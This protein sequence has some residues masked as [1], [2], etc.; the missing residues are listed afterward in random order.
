METGIKSRF[1]HSVMPRRAAAALEDR[2]F[3]LSGGEFPK[4]YMEQWAR[5]KGLRGFQL[6][7]FLQGTRKEMQALLRAKGMLQRGSE[8]PVI[9]SARGS[10]TAVSFHMPDGEPMREFVDILRFY[11]RQIARKRGLNFQR[12]YRS[13]DWLTFEFRIPVKRLREAVKP[14]PPSP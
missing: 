2:F 8:R 7:E 13:P 3:A 10:T 12:K 9:R 14:Q 1:F 4:A 6:H 5:K 11:G